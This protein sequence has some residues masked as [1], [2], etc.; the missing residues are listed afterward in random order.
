MIQNFAEDERRT[1]AAERQLPGCHLVEDGSKGE[2]VAAGIQIFRA[3]LLRG[4]VGN[5]AER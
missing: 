2:Q 5:G 1:F 3:S 4:H